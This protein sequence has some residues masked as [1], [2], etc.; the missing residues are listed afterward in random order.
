MIAYWKRVAGEP[1]A[2]KEKLEEISPVNEAE[3]FTAPVL[4]I[5]GKDDTVVDFTQG[6]IMERALERAGKDVTFVE[7]KDED[8]W[9]SQGET[10][11]E[12]L[13]AMSDFVDQYIGE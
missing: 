8:H 2:E 5:H 10:R 4:L 6:R 1:R 7:L 3:N 11:I 12:T 9:L 13:K